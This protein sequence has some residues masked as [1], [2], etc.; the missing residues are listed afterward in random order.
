MQNMH[1]DTRDGHSRRV[2]R[3]KNTG[4]IKTR[5]HQLV[6][7]LLVSPLRGKIFRCFSRRLRQWRVLEE[8]ET[9]VHVR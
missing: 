3:Q 5:V 8:E 1:K 6:N 2:K 4:E 7:V 9:V